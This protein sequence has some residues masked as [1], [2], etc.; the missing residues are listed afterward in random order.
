MEYGESAVETLEREFREET[1]LQVAV[2]AL[3][4]V[5]EFRRGALHAL[6][7]FFEVSVIGGELKTGSDPELTATI[8]DVR[9]LSTQDIDALPPEAKH[10]AFGLVPT[11]GRFGELNGYFRI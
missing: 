9:L 7:M 11:S 2:G 10:G 6:E 4:F 8:Q 5:T 1:G 3:L